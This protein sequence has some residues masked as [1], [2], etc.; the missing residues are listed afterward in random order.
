[1][2]GLI[3]FLNHGVL[4]FTGRTAECDRIVEFWRGVTEAPG[5][6]AMLLVGEAGVG[7]SRLVEEVVHRVLTAAGAVVHTKLYP[8]TPTAI[9]PL[10]ARAIGRFA[11]SHPSL[12][13]EPGETLGSVTSALRRLARL[14]QT[15]VV[16]EDVHLF[17]PETL[18]DLATLLGALADEQFVLLCA[19]R[20]H[21][22]PVR[23]VLE[24]YMVG[25]IELT[26]LRPD[27]MEEILASVLGELGGHE[28]IGPFLAATAGNPLAVRSALRGAIQSG[29]LVQNEEDGRWRPTTDV[30]SF[31]G[32]LDRNVRLLSEGMAVHLSAAERAGAEQIACLGEVVAHE[33]AC[34]L[35]AD[36]DRL[37]ESLTF[38]GILSTMGES[39]PPL[40]GES[41]SRPLLA[42]THSLLHRR[43]TEEAE[44]DV[45]G[46]IALLASDLPLY[47]V[48][49]FQLLDGRIS[50]QSLPADV[51]HAAVLCTIFVAQRLDGATDWRMA[52]PLW[53]IAEQLFDAASP[54]LDDR[55]RL[56]LHARLLNCKL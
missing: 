36:G 29:A 21:D 3:D 30:R 26:G 56:V 4:P 33:T 39:V 44:V 53:T 47:S 12:K 13:I 20:P 41:S 16:I 27:A 51:L 1:M 31:T 19:A 24:R 10:L 38:K 11:S 8:E 50:S 49:P 46:M 28:L 15:L 48:V 45:P 7:K 40:R 6:Q 22:L 43:F 55:T 42:F 9:A 52:L 17:A 54:L 37:L 34:R 35:I 2:R 32:M 23:G 18:A 14:R 5:L 25:E